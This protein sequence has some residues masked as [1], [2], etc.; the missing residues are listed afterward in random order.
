MKDPGLIYF[1]ANLMVAYFFGAVPG[2]ISAAMMCGYMGLGPLMPGSAFEHTSQNELR[3]FWTAL[4]L[5][6]FSIIIGV[7][8]ARIR[9][10]AVKAFLARQ[11]AELEAGKRE[12]TELSLRESEEL[13]GLIVESSRDAIVATD[14]DGGIL[15]WNQNAESLFSWSAQ[16]ATGRSFA[17]LLGIERGG[18]G[19]RVEAL[20]RDR[21]GRY[22]AV[23]MYIAA[24]RGREGSIWIAFLRDITERKAW[25]EKIQSLNANL[26]QR[27]KERTAE[28]EAKNAELEGFSYAISHDMRSPLRTIV[29]N[30]RFVLE[31]EG[32]RVSPAGRAQL[33]R[34]AGAALRMSM[35]VDDLLKYARLSSEGVRLEQVDLSSVAETAAADVR[36]EYPGAKIVVT[37]GITAQADQMLMAMVFTNLFDNACKYSKPGSAPAVCFGVKEHEGKTVYFV[38]DEGIGI[39]MQYA[40]TLF[41]P[42]QRLHAQSE[43]PGTGIGLANVRRIVERHG[44]RIWLESQEGLGTTIFFTLG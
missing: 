3:I 10:E 19:E 35:L 26:E 20:A 8:R 31:D 25:E 39:D 40:H 29:A 32:E 37:P 33:E 14:E 4:L 43:I 30:A 5:G 17:E 28:L 34:L 22:V 16:E 1:V 6:S 23:E 38:A 2:L 44:G 15:L 36:E 9:G 42:F 7:V 41:Q 24:H 21:E 13:T 18:L 11:S 12:Q 27:V